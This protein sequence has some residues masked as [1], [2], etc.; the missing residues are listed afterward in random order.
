MSGNLY[1]VATPVGNLEDITYRAVRVLSEVDLV[2]CED[3][4]HAKKLL[5]RYNIDTGTTSYHEHNEETK[6]HELIDEMLKSKNIAIISDAGTPLVSDPGYRLI[7]QAIGNN[8]DVISVPG[9]SSVLAALTSSGLP[10]DSFCFIGF[11]PR[12]EKKKTDLLDGVSDY[13]QTIIIFESAK[14]IKKSLETLL[15]VLG[16]RRAALC[17]EITKLHEE[18]LRGNVSELIEKISN[19]DPLKGEITLVVEGYKADSKRISSDML[20]S[21]DKR[22]KTLKKLGLSL[23]DAV[24]V[25]NHDFDLP[26]KK[27]YNKALTIW[28]NTQK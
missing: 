28:G 22:L 14:R 15:R 10:T 16:D 26:R 25:V 24:K 7:E 3:T 18:I 2:A 21:I 12:T 27:I 17:R 9:A 4:R 13:G 6:C 19:R 20:S 11:L 23:K 5:S 1:I 8:I